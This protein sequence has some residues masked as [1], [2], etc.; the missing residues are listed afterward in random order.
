MSSKEKEKLKQQILLKGNVPKHVAI[1][2]DGNGRWAKKRGLPRIAGHKKGVDSVREIVRLCPELGIEI[3]T[4]YT[5]SM[6]NWNRPKTEISALM[7]LLLNTIRKE[8]DEL[9]KNNVKVNTLGILSD[10]PA[11]ARKGMEEAIERTKNNSGLILNLA[12]SYSSRVEIVDMVKRI[13]KKVKNNEVEVD[14]INEMFVSENLH[15]AGLKDPDLLI[16]TSGVFRISN[17]LLWQL[18]YTEI[19]ITDVLW[20][21]FRAKEFYKAIID[22]QN[23][24]RRFGMVSEQISKNSNIENIVSF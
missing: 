22:Y 18:A 23:R 11:N 10:L 19:Y 2:M 24:E 15:T 1:I 14:D 16:R 6:E 3:L 9:V 21:D 12:L 13:A 7:S 17:F 8:I 20:P 5:F 4:L